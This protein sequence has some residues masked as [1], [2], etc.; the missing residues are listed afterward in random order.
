MQLRLV[1]LIVVIIILHCYS[2]KHKRIT[3]VNGWHTI[4]IGG[5]E[6]DFP[7]DFDL[8]EEKGI[9]S[10]VGHINGDSMRFGF[11]Y[12][13]YSGNLLQTPIEYL[14]K[15]RWLEDAAIAYTK[16]GKD[17]PIV[18]M[19]GARVATKEDSSIGPGCDYV[20]NC[21]FDTTMFLYPI[22]VPEEIKQCNFEIDTFNGHYRKI[23]YSKNPSKGLTGIYI[24]DTSINSMN[25]PLSLSL[26]A[27]NL[28]AN[29]QKL[30]L[31]ILKSVRPVMQ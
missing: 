5:Y 18:R 23:V 15:K 26:S 13:Y 19:L 8:Y 11:D 1:S 14:N 17:I 24:A 12:G 25:S 16:F 27:V 10:Y 29:Q 4:K 31:V 20:A 9:D 21:Y 7:A 28:N 3:L 6:A 2:C 30:A 22:Y